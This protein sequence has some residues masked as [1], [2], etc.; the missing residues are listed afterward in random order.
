MASEDPLFILYTSGT[1][2]KPKGVVHTHA[3]Y[4]LG[5][6]VTTREV[7]GIE[8]DDVY[9]CAADIGWV[10]GHSYIVYGPMQ[11]G[12]TQI[13]YEGAPNWPEPD[14]M[15]QIV[16]AEGVSIFYTAPT[17][18]RSF[19]KW[20][21]A[22]PKRHDLSS[23]RLL[24]SVGEPIQSRGLA[25]VSRDHRQSMLSHSG[26]L[27][28]DGNRRHRN[29]ASARRHHHQAGVGDGSLLRYRRRRTG[30]GGPRGQ[31]W[32]W[33]LAIRRPWPSMM[34]G[35]WGDDVRI[36]GELEKNIAIL[37]PGDYSGEMSILENVPRSATTIALDDVKA[38]EFSREN[39]E[40]LT[41]GNPQIALKLLKG[42]VQRIYA[43]KRTFMILTLD[44][45]EAKVADVFL[46]LAENLSID[47]TS[48]D[49]IEFKNTVDDLSHRAGIP[50]GQCREVLNH[51][52]AQRRI[53]LYPD[54]IVVKN[55]ND[56]ARFVNSR[57]K[58][59]EK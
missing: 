29:L 3:G 28:A 31:R 55:I 1:T 43:Q 6:Q 47:T 18:I 56:F 48:V 26:Y 38:L 23:L 25:V 13:I 32:G 11:L 41:L 21:D 19:M 42:F 24:G 49:S 40:V 54:R 30:R 36:I 7:F 35:L 53:E 16:A 27:V 50:A 59:Q 33:S 12:A 2:G 4:L 57:R 58:H 34:R 10:T 9:W 5:T 39:F 20:G 8:P 52:V 45:V 46:M 37:N 15:W 14:R 44:D 51:F 17:A 22:W